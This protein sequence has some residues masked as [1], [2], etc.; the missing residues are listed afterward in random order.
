MTIENCNKMT[1][2]DIIVVLMQMR[3]ALLFQC[4]M[5]GAMKVSILYIVVGY[6][7]FIATSSLFYSQIVYIYFVAGEHGR[8]NFLHGY[9]H[10][11]QL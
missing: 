9:I 7:V 11:F 6:C 1:S 3:G 10:M 4:A 5:P 8:D 2:D